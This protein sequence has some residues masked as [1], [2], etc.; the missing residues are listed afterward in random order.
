MRVS[1]LVFLSLTCSW[2]LLG[3]AQ[4]YAGN[5]ML[6]AGDKIQTNASNQ[7]SFLVKIKQAG[8]YRLETHGESDTYCRLNGPQ[9]GLMQTDNNSGVAKNCRMDVWLSQGLYNWTVTKDKR[10]VK[11]SVTQFKPQG[12][13]TPLSMGKPLVDELSAM[14][15]RSFQFKVNRRRW[16]DLDVYG[17]TV[18]NCHLLD[19]RGWLT[20]I[21]TSL[22]TGNATSQGYLRYCK[23]YGLVEPGTYTLQVVGRSSQATARSKSVTNGSIMVVAG[24]RAF[25]PFRWSRVNLRH[26]NKM[27]YWFTVPT[28]WGDAKHGKVKVLVQVRMTHGSKKTWYTTLQKMGWY[29]SNGST[30]KGC[31]QNPKKLHGRRCDMIA[32]IEAGKRHQLEVAGAIGQ[33]FWIRYVLIFSQSQLPIGRRIK[34]L[35]QPGVGTYASFSVTQPGRYRIES[36]PHTRSCLLEREIRPNS[37][38]KLQIKSIALPTK[39]NTSSV[40]TAN[41][42]RRQ[43]NWRLMLD[44]GGTTQW[45]NIKTEST[46]I[47]GTHGKFDTYCTLYNQYGYTVAKNDDQTKKIR[48]C[49]IERRVQPGLYRINIRAYGKRG[50]ARAYI[51]YQGDK[52]NTAVP[53]TG[54]CNVSAFL[55]PGSYRIR[56]SA[57]GRLRLRE[58]IVHPMPLKEDQAVR[59]STL[60]RTVNDSPSQ[61]ISVPLVIKKNKLWVSASNVTTCRLFRGN[62][63]VQ[64]GKRKGRTCRMVGKIAPGSYTLKLTQTPRLRAKR[65]NWSGAP[66]PI[67]IRT[68]SKVDWNRNTIKKLPAPPQDVYKAIT[69]SATQGTK[70]ESKAVTLGNN[71]TARVDWEIPSLGMYHFQTEGLVP[72]HCSLMNS[73]GILVKSS[74]PTLSQRNCRWS[75]VLQPG[76]YSVHVRAASNSKGRV[77][78]KLS[79][80]S[81][82]KMGKL[83]QATNL[84]EK[85]GTKVAYYHSFDAKKPGKYHLQLQSIDTPLAC[86]LVDPTNWVHQTMTPCGSSMELVRGPHTLW[87]HPPQTAARYRLMLNHGKH[88][89]RMAP[90]P[91]YRLWRHIKSKPAVVDLERTLTLRYR[92]PQ[93]CDKLV[94]KIPT[95]MKVTFSLS[96]NLVARLF[97]GDRFVAK[98]LNTKESPSQQTIQLTAGVYHMVVQGNNT[99]LDSYTDYK[100]STHVIATQPGARL[101]RKV[102]T[103]ITLSMKQAGSVSIQT[104]GAKDNWCR[105]QRINGETLSSNDDATAKRWDCR[106]DRWLPAGNYKVTVDGTPGDA[107]LSL[108]PVKAAKGELAFDNVSRKHKLV[109]FQRNVFTVKVM[110][111]QIAQINTQFPHQKAPLHCLLEDV[112]RKLKVY[113]SISG[114]CSPILDLRKGSYKWHVH[115]KGEY[116][117][118][119]TLQGAIPSFTKL[120]VGKETKV[121]F[122]PGKT[123]FFLAKLNAWTNYQWKLPKDKRSSLTC[124]ANNGQGTY[125]Q[126]HDCKS[127]IIRGNNE[128]LFTLRS[129]I[130]QEL[131]LTLEA[132]PLSAGQSYPLQLA[133]GSNAKITLQINKAGLYRL[134]TQTKGLIRWSSHISKYLG[135][136][137]TAPKGT[138]QTLV[139][140][141]KGSHTVKVTSKTGSLQTNIHETGNVQ[142]NRV[143]ALPE[144]A[145]SKG[146]G[147]HTGTLAAKASALWQ[148]SQSKAHQITVTLQGKG[149]VTALTSDNKL[150]HRCV[151]TGLTTCRWFVSDETKG[152][153]LFWQTAST[154]T[155]QV[156]ITGVPY[157]NTQVTLK[158]GSQWT[159]PTNIQNASSWTFK[160]EGEGELGFAVIGG[161]THCSFPHQPDQW[162]S[163]NTVLNVQGSDLVR[164]LSSQTPSRVVV[165]QKGKKNEAI[166]AAAIPSKTTKAA[167]VTFHTQT[168]LTAKQGNISWHGFALKDAQAIAIQTSG[169]ASRCGLFSKESGKLLQ[170]VNGTK[171]CSFSGALQAGSYLFGIFAEANLS[172]GTL[173]ISNKPLLLLEEGKKGSMLLGSGQDVWFTFKVKHNK[174]IGVGAIGQHDDLVCTVFHANGTK[175]ATGCQRYLKLKPGQYNYR[176]SLPSNAKPTQVR[177]ILRGQNPPPDQ[178][179]AAYLRKLLQQASTD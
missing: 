9:R 49:R 24:D 46:L 68:G 44:K 150:Q 173:S 55:T 126:Y 82:K 174:R 87:L 176:V 102:P 76:S 8:E 153:K 65:Y 101:W 73:S 86:T 175:V 90:T 145:E 167:S 35:D 107:W 117:Q 177:A 59:I 14:Q 26:H 10:P 158:A 152:T 119:M 31:Y 27:K 88:P 155:Y 39:Q 89:K 77:A 160:V 81:A 13:T 133:Q 2:L 58:M 166:W 6:Q 128:V 100:V 75:G 22:G 70:T 146:L 40:T 21:N 113:E 7:Q 94:F 147:A 38:K 136:P 74:N 67:W 69:H 151:S 139:Y 33:K 103:S 78:I 156:A 159:F 28:S 1:S 108:Q 144:K 170:V 42:D 18:K 97:L 179:P 141:P 19:R 169:G 47:F 114:Q 105:L 23:L 168:K 95:G 84:T 161:K 165:F 106:M 20:S 130:Q 92:T 142:A 11:V 57:S 140:L 134:T 118:V 116:S 15:T 110:E 109:P 43:L 29:T 83:E 79:K 157:G 63:E 149:S 172:Q 48:S 131:Q 137:E 80:Y 154:M 34:L 98:W 66:Q 148:L 111:R 124:S 60:H 50:F 143:A 121:T 122:E 4:S 132:N 64:R 85:M 112:S 56:A 178:P 129:S 171:G 41:E 96:S 62:N 3:G 32:T 37:W 71:Q 36:W 52:R 123:A 162:T 51:K 54:G 17:V 30:V 45:I 16:L 115:H 135:Y 99:S 72:V 125:I 61:S 120:K 164:V 138:T 5:H 12:T 104:E 53:V 25:R 91:S 127:G 93:P 163:C